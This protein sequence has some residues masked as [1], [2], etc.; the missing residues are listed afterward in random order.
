M[1]E[2]D[3]GQVKVGQAVTFSADAFPDRQFRGVVDQVRLAATTASNVVTY[4]VVV[5]VDNGDGTLLPGLT[6]NAE[7]EVTRKPNVLKVSNAAL[8]FKP[9]E[10]SA[11]A[12]ELASQG[13]TAAMLRGGGS[14]AV[15][16]LQKTA[17]T[18]GLD[19]RQ[20]AAF[21]AALEQMKQQQA[22]RMAQ[23]QERMQQAQQNA[24][25]VAGGGMG[26]GVRISMGGGGDSSIQAQMRQRARERMNQQ[27]GAFRASLDL[28]L[29]H[30]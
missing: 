23:M 12:Q 30:I 13:P 10:N 21:D 18:L 9:A 3:I 4:P 8:R 1:D 17:A 28:S 19:L 29:I 16:D 14:G 15:E 24:N 20:Q 27:F 26:G 6:V 25:R 11:L 22:Q 7:I 5:A 2:S